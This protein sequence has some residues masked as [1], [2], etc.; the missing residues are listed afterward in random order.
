MRLFIYVI[1]VIL[2]MDYR[3]SVYAVV[4][5]VPRGRVTTYKLVAAALGNPRGC[6]AVGNALNRN[7]DPEKVPCYRVVKSDGRLGGYAGGLSEKIRRLRADG[8]E[9]RDGMVLGLD[10]ILFTPVPIKRF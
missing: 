3:E 2:V 4:M 7:S 6:R 8:I 5:Q 1:A 10:R 9:V